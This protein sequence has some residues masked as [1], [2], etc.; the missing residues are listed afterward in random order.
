MTLEGICDFI[1]VTLE[2]FYCTAQLQ[3]SFINELGNVVYGQKY[4]LYNAYPKP[5]INLIHYTRLNLNVI[6]N[7]NIFDV[8]TVDFEYKDVEGNTQKKSNI[9]ISGS[10]I[11]TPGVGYMECF[12]DMNIIAQENTLTQTFH[13]V[14]N[15]K[16]IDS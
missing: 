12:L 13:F 9:P 4:V 7:L 15:I 1:F 11:P 8:G 14:P 16:S 5:N 6:I 2:G 10:I 3:S